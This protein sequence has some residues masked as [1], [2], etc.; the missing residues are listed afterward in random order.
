MKLAHTF[1]GRRWACGA[2][3]DSMGNTDPESTVRPA[4]SVGG[5]AGLRPAEA[6]DGEGRA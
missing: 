5:G 1:L 2:G 3:G 6:G 4:A